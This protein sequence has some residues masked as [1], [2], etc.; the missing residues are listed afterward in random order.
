MKGHGK[1]EDKAVERGQVSKEEGRASAPILLKEGPGAMLPPE[2][3]AGWEGLKQRASKGLNQE[4]KFGLRA[5]DWP[6][7]LTLCPWC[8][9][10]SFSLW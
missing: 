2:V 1:N 5:L 3:S 4:S 8:P 7:G 9:G 10:S 6:P